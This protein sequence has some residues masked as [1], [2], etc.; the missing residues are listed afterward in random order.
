MKLKSHKINWHWIG[1]NESMMDTKHTLELFEK[2]G[3][4]FY[5]FQRI[6]RSPRLTEEL[7]EKHMDRNG[8]SANPLIIPRYVESMNACMNLNLL[9]FSQNP[10]LT[11]EIR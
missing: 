8:L 2:Y 1:G 7:I 3:D 11:I 5:R 9:W 6:W 4:K 10:G